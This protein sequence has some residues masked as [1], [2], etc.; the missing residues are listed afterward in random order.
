VRRGGE[1][2]GGKA[3]CIITRDLHLNDTVA[4]TT[5]QHISYEITLL[6]KA[7]ENSS[8]L[9][10][11]WKESANPLLRLSSR[12][13]ISHH[14]ELNIFLYTQYQFMLERS[15]VTLPKNPVSITDTAST[16]FTKE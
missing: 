13:K 15:S 1:R 11:V 8:K 9:T 5:K 3:T 14:F 7:R 4:L 12:K 6:D 16:T 2:R 10:N